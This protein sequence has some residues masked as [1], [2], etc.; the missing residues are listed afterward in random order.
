MTSAA[1]SSSAKLTARNMDGDVDR[2]SGNVATVGSVDASTVASAVAVAALA[3]VL[4]AW[5]P[6]GGSEI[7]L[8]LAALTDVLKD[9]R[10]R[11]GLAD[12]W[13]WRVLRG[14]LADGAVLLLS[15]AVDSRAR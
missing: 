2:G 6:R 11:G 5:R 9:W 3:I 10:L 12:R 15:T 7:A 8:A 13:V 1:A 14:G 4:E